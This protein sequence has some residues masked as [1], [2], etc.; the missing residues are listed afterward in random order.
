MENLFEKYNLTINDILEDRGKK[1]FPA[2]GFF[3]GSGV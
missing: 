1:E 2:C 3:E